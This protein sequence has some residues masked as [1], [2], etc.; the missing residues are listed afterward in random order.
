MRTKQ[1]ILASQTFQSVVN[2]E[3]QE[4]KF[5]TKGEMQQTYLT[6]CWQFDG[7]SD[8]SPADII[9]LFK[10]LSEKPYKMEKIR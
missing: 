1:S 9:L 5:Y 6:G 2:K 4:L 8:K 10:T 7:H 3:F